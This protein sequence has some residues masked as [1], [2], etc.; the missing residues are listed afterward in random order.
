MNKIYYST[1]KAGSDRRGLLTHEVT[2]TTANLPKED[3]QNTGSL[4]IRTT[5]KLIGKCDTVVFKKM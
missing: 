3:I 1:G 2:N 4:I 5:E